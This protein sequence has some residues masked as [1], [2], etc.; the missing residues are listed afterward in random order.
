M[1]NKSISIAAFSVLEITLVLALLGILS[2]LFFGAI[3]RFQATMHNDIQIKSELNSFFQFRSN[4]WRELDQSDSI[5]ITN[6]QLN[7]FIQ[8]KVV[9]YSQE[10]STSKLKWSSNE[11]ERIFDLEVNTLNIINEKQLLFDLT[12]KDQPLRIHYPIKQSKADKINH[13]FNSESWK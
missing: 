9:V 6:K 13:Y 8:N 3:N 1:Q 7:L 10:S 12:W 11:A 4:L 2:A 5:K